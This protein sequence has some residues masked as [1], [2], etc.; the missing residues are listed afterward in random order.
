MELVT[1]KNHFHTQKTQTITDRHQVT[2]KMVLVGQGCNRV[3]FLS[4]AEWR[5][6]KISHEFEMISFKTNK[7]YT[8]R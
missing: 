6:V 8:P 2:Y 3:F 1:R 4:H 5:G 7:F